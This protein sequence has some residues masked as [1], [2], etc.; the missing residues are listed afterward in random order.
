M[1]KNVFKKAGSIL[2]ETILAVA[3][4]G[5]IYGIGWLN[6]LKTGSKIEDRLA[7][8]IDN[9]D[10]DNSGET[11]EEVEEETAEEIIMTETPEEDSGKQED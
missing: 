5:T 10:T 1:L 4:I 2:G 8:A 11:T 9:L 7:S 3:G 6:G